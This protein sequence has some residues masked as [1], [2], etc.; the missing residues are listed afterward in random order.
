VNLWARKVA[1]NQGDIRV[2]LGTDGAGVAYVE[3]SIPLPA[4]VPP[5]SPAKPPVA[6]RLRTQEVGN[7]A[8][9]LIEALFITETGAES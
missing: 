7:L 6:L 8:D 3:I 2:R 1:T 5:W 4:V 9:V